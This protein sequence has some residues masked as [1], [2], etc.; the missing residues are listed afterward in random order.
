MAEDTLKF[1][2]SL[3]WDPLRCYSN[4]L[5]TIRL[6]IL[7]LFFVSLR[8]LNL[9]QIFKFVNSQIFEI[10]FLCNFSSHFLENE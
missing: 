4:C 7:S 6:L 2:K 5:G 10:S 8:L 9:I 3:Y 1:F